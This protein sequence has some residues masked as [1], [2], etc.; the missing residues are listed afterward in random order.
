MRS[1][2]GLLKAGSILILD[3]DDMIAPLLSFA[4]ESE[5]CM[6]PVIVSAA[7]EVEE[8]VDQNPHEYFAAAVCFNAPDA[9]RILELLTQNHIPVVVY[10]SSFDDT[11]RKGLSTWG[12]AEVVVDEPDAI[13]SQVVA[14]LSV[15]DANRKIGILVVDDSRSMRSA[16]LRF[17]AT[18]CY[19]IFEAKNGQEALEQLDK[20]PI[21]NLVIT[22]NEM[23]EMDGYSLV[24]QIRKTRSK[25]ELAVIG[26]AAQT[27]SNLSVKFI[28]SGANDFLKKPFVKEE[29]YCR[30]NH[31]VEMLNRIRIIRELSYKD[32]LTKLHNRRYF[33]ENCDGFAR[34]AWDQNLTVSVAM[35]DIDHF[36]NVNDTY[37]HDGGDRALQVVAGILQDG[38]DS[39]ALIARFGGEEFCI[40]MA[41]SPTDD[42]FAR[43]DVLRRKVESSI[44]N[45][46]FEKTSVTVSM[47]VC[48]KEASVDDMIK[49]ADSRLYV[50]KKSGRNQVVIS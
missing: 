41:H 35:V 46:G 10:G 28:T 12:I 33:F 11:T 16:L 50:A 29:L 15:M 24:K 9:N 19:Q 14:A 21:I 31:N 23:P 42:I 36:K 39:G 30:V 4:I 17:L 49:I 32:P 43:Y 26:I 13:T 20:Y 6:H 45:M 25:D 7:A 47:G 38:L 2:E 8:L 48:T 1:K 34:V 44:I 27:N 40:I 22:D 37:G 5:V 3:G 18:R